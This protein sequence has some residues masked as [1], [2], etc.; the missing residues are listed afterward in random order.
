MG[1]LGGCENV[2]QELRASLAV[3]C[4][5][6]VGDDLSEKSARTE[7]TSG[8]ERLMMVQVG[9]SWLGFVK[10]VERFVGCGNLLGAWAIMVGP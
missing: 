4:L 9:S 3:I 10:E 6:I 5:E 7:G 8:S 1:I 2:D